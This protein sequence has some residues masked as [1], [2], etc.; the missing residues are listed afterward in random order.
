MVRQTELYKLER[1][2]SRHVYLLGRRI[3][4]MTV[5]AIVEAI[6][7]ACL[8]GRKMTVAN[9]NVHSF[10]LSMQIPWFY[11]FLQSAEIAHCDSVGILKAISYMGLDLPIEYR[12]S[13]TL[14]MPQLL[15][16]CNRHG[17]SIFLLGSKPK[18]LEAALAR[19][20]KQYP[21]I[22]VAGH[23]GYFA[24]EDPAQN[25]AVIQQINRVPPN[26][27][28][29]G[30]GMPTQENWIRMHR[31]RL[32]VNAIMPGG[33]IIDRVAGIVSDCPA[34]ISNMGLEWLYRL[35]REPKRLAPRYLLGNPAFVLSIA[36]A[37]LYAPPLEV[38][39]MQ[40]ISGS[41]L[42][43]KDNSDKLF[44]TS[45]TQNESPATIGNVKRLGDY[46]IEA[47]LLTRA[48]IETALCEQEVTGMRLGEILVQ[49][50]YIKEQTIEYLMK[51]VILP[52]RAVTRESLMDTK[53]MA[54]HK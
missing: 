31:S 16:H 51:N 35:C 40:P 38:Q 42:E 14:L 54:L 17:F 47:G 45:T 19:L 4:C 50:G 13:Y 53:T 46:L 6:H 9:Y 12:A 23:H 29:V 39:D 43:A 30:M 22:A 32:N 34:F 5:P 52:D 28:V 27:L 15:E 21:N 33:A 7:T 3:T 49:K 10:N 48:H 2:P 24:M 20:K 18:Y 36:L 11:N 1:L 41:S 44:S 8:E 26:I 37:K 25:E